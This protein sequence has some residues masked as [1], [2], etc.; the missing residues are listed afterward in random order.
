MIRN[1]LGAG[2]GVRLAAGSH[3]AAE[4][5]E[6]V[7]I[8]TFNMHHGEGIDGVYDAR[9]IGR[10]TLANFAPEPF[11]WGAGRCPSLP[12]RRVEI[13]D[14]HNPPPVGPGSDAGR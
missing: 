12:T 11:G 14:A 4:Q 13:H 6:T 8:M 1:G 7:R 9:R 10:M 3:A 5:P 2:A